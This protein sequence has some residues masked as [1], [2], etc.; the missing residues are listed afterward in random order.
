METFLW[1]VVLACTGMVLLFLVVEVI[2]ALP[3]KETQQRLRE[4]QEQAELDRRGQ[5]ALEA[6]RELGRKYPRP[7]N[8]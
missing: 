5:A 2:D 4:A 7:K 8:Y 1:L 3:T 6:L